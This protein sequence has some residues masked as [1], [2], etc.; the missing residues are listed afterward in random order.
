MNKSSK[1]GIFLSIILL[2]SIVVITIPSNV[3]AEE[4]NVKSFAFEETTIIEF[5]NDSDGEINTFRIWLGSDFSFKSFKTEKGWM[6]VKTSLG[7]IVFSS[8]ETIKPGESVKFGVKTDKAKPGINWK[9]LDKGDNQIG[10]GKVFPGELPR[11]IQNTEN[12]GQGIFT[13]STF[14]IIPDSP[15]VGSSIR[16]TGD[17]FAAS[18]EFDFYIDSKKIDS[19]ETDEN[20]HFMTTIK[21]P[22]DQIADR[23]D[24]KIKD[25]YGDEKKISLRIEDIE[26]RISVTENIRLTIKG[27]PDVVHRGDMLEIFGTGEPN[28]V[29]TAEVKNFDGE[30]VNSRTAKI[31][32]KGS[33]KLDETVIVA[34]DTPF[35]KYSATVSDGKNNVLIHWIVETDK[36]IL[37][38]PIK[39]MFKAG[40]LIKFNGTAI[41]N[42]SLELIL[43]D[44]QGNERISDII[45]I[46]DS[47]VVEFEYQTVE[48]VDKEGT[49]TLIATQEQN[50]ELIFV[51][52]GEPLSIPVKI[53]F[54]K[55]NYKSTETAI[56]TF[57][58]EKSDKLSIIIINPSGNVRNEISVQLQ[59]DGRGKD[60]LELKGFQSGVYHAVIKKSGIETVARFTVGLQIGSGE[61][62]ANVTKIQYNPGDT[63][64]FLGETNPNALL[65]AILLDSN[66]NEIK[67][68]GFPSDKDGKFNEDSFRIPS[69]ALPGI[70]KIRISSGDNFYDLDIN[71]SPFHTE[72]IVVS[73]IEGET[74]GGIGKNIIIMVNG[75]TPKNT[76]FIEI[77]SEFG[78]V[79][80]DS[81]RCVATDNASCEVP[82]LVIKDLP[83]GSYIVKVN[84]STSSA[85]DTF[86]IQ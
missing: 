10:I 49:W 61:I 62:E 82:W 80:D 84:D 16:V 79:I 5:T 67:E 70:W 63:I 86:E 43:E 50:K 20:G 12:V 75:A 83:A 9:A 14:R 4:I 52:Y 55:S 23:V 46:G 64:L 26:N 34:F 47:G 17:K 77:V 11:A 2:F 76:V 25:K 71:V 72:G 41:P 53:E 44:V 8:S 36:V 30:I 60:N 29:I 40:D 19:F 15:N 28:S 24:F 59:P 78:D 68:I 58:G 1:R 74:L 37:I 57:R 73:V 35:G 42:V 39:S 32:N 33:W 65:T 85:E 56:I 81:L 13:E 51:G 7:V 18:Q 38:E 54:D 69:D 66:N 6:G 27:I 3:S 22:E 48:N 21:I 45:N 31:D